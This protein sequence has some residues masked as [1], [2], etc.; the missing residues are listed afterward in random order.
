MTP[1]ERMLA[2]YKLLQPDRVPISPEIWSATVLEFKNEPFFRYIG[3]FADKDFIDAWFETQQ[4]FGCDP[5]IL[6]GLDEPTEGENFKILKKSYFL[7]SET[8]QTEV[9]INTCKGILYEVRRTNEQYDGWCIEHPVKNFV[10]DMPTYVQVTLTDPWS[11]ETNSINRALSIVGDNGLVSA[12]LGELFI[13]YLAFARE[14]NIGQTLIDLFDYEDYI[15]ELHT[16]YIDY[17][18]KKVERLSSV[19]GLDCVFIN[20][21]Y[22]DGGVLGPNYYLKWEV[23]LLST[24]ARKAK[25]FG[26]VLHLHQHGKCRRLLNMIADTGANLVDSL[27]RPTANG[28]VVDLSKVKKEVGSKIALK[29]NIDPINVLKNGTRAQ[30]SEQVKACIEDAAYNGGY[31]LGTGDSVVEGTP[32][33]NIFE[34]VNAGMKYGNYKN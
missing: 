30:I 24:I 10:R 16:R 6:V 8:I 3:P 31:I 14:G 4:Y 29:G 17:M 15:R 11:H 25:E 5:W 27:E 26:L 13:S 2:A 32:F 21:G 20:C 23:P 22:S 9:I 34:L 28:D 1:R 7:N 12:N 18:C 33:E 19:E